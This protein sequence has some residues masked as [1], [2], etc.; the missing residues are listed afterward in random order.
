MGLA[1]VAGL[2][3]AAL[4]FI[5]LSN[6][7]DDDKGTT[8][9]PGVQLAPVVVAAV[10]MAAGDTIDETDLEVRQI[11]VDLVLTGSYS[12][13]DTLI[14]ETTSVPVAAGEQLLPA[15]IGTP[16]EGEGIGYVLEPGRRAVGISADEVRAAGGH[17]LPGDRVDL[18][19]ITKDDSG[20]TIAVQTVLQDVEVL[21]VAD[22]TQ[23]PQAATESDDATDDRGSSGVVPGDVE[24]NPGASSLT[25][26]VTPDQA[27]IIVAIEYGDRTEWVAVQRGAGDAEIVTLPPT[28]FI[29]PTAAPAPAE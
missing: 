24:E 16:I 20:N 6:S 13:A 27:Q 10:D 15:K 21:G 29:A 2:V 22:D 23:E 4:V 12:E 8:V 3:A 17:L 14:G 18:L 7:S 25:L 5:A 11:P 9:S 1:L 19:S 28:I 26:S